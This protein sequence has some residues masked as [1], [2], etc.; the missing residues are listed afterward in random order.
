MLIL[1]RAVGGSPVREETILAGGPAAAPTS[2]STEAVAA[3]GESAMGQQG[4]TT[5]RRSCCRRQRRTR[6]QEFSQAAFHGF[7]RA[8]RRAPAPERAAMHVGSLLA[9]PWRAL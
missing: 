7:P 4:P 5:M 1:D 2:A 9:Q 3:S 6:C 8:A